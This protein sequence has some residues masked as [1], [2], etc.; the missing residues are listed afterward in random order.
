MDEYEDINERI[1]QLQIQVYLLK[2]LLQ[3][4]ADVLHRIAKAIE[5]INDG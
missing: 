4:T 2:T 1:A 5:D 3:Q